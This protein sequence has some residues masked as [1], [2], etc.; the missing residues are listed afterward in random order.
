MRF[1]QLDLERHGGVL[2]GIGIL[3]DG[4]PV[5]AQVTEQNTPSGPVRSLAVFDLSIDLTGAPKV[6]ETLMK[7]ATQPPR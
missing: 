7:K 6:R 1:K 5:W 4:T 2:R 3:D